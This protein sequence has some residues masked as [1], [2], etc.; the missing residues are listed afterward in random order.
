M[1]FGWFTKINIKIQMVYRSMGMDLMSQEVP[2]ILNFLSC[3][4]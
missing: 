2:F 1:E 3:R 4:V